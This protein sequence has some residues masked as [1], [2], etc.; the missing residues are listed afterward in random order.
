MPE[1]KSKMDEFNELD[2]PIVNEESIFDQNIKLKNKKNE[3]KKSSVNENTTQLN[4]KNLEENDILIKFLME[5]NLLNHEQ[6]VLMVHEL[7]K[8]PDV[9]IT[10]MLINLRLVEQKTIQLFFH[11]QYKIKNLNIKEI[12]IDE[13]LLNAIPREIVVIELVVPLCIIGKQLYLAVHDIYNIDILDRVKI[14]IQKHFDVIQVIP[15]YFAENEIVYAIDTYYGYEMSIENILREIDAQ[16]QMADNEEDG[17]ESPVVRLIDTILEDAIKKDVSD[18]HMEPCQNFLRIRYRIDGVLIQRFNISIDYWQSMLTRVKIISNMDISERRHPQDGRISMDVT[19]K[20]IDFRVAS[21]PTMDGE[22]VVMRILDPS[23]M[24]LD[25]RT[26]GFGKRNLKAVH[27]ALECPE[28]IILIVGPTGSGK[29]TTLYSMIQHINEMDINIMTIEDP[30]E[31][32]L[33][34]IR[35]SNASRESGAMMNFEE[36]IR[37]LMRQDPDTIV[38]GEIRDKDSAVLASRA[39]MTGHQVLSSLH[40]NNAVNAITRLIDIGIEP[41]NIAD[42]IVCLMSQRLARRLCPTCKEKIE[43]NEEQK[44][45]LGDNYYKEGMTIFQAKHK[46]C[47]QCNNSGYKGR[48]IIP[49]VLLID[50]EIKALISRNATVSEINKYVR[51]NT[52]FIP[53]AEFGIQ[54]VVEGIL[55]FE[56]LSGN[57]NLSE[58]TFGN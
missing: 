3:E 24:S 39:A 57:I 43:P 19:G 33:S 22:N 10:E 12:A 11:S 40:A 45:I 38:I 55:D 5:K 37:S 42:V 14:I 27:K 50:S 2:G 46:G 15:V 34:L 56:E 44:K 32:T 7:E 18:I 52:D 4:E 54:K 1:K 35:Q 53:M 16:D 9:L 41:M 23:R 20:H 30:V 36:G 13:K 51:E 21:H 6:V 8:T 47:P 25:I 26:V 29:T 49:E 17:G 28:G 31:Y 58:Y 48:V